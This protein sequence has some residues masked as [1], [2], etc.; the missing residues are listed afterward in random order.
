MTIVSIAK[1]VLMSGLAL[2]KKDDN[3]G[4]VKSLNRQYKKLP[5]IVN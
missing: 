4:L 3:L 2:A 1:K 5:A